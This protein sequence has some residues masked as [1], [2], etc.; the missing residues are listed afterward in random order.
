M[1]QSK[2]HYSVNGKQ[3]IFLHIPKTAGVSMLDFV[4]SHNIIINGHDIRSPQY[5]SLY[6]YTQKFTPDI[7]AFCFV[8]NPWDRA[9]SAYYYLEQEMG[10]EGDIADKYRYTHQYESFDD[11]VV[12]G[13]PHNGAFTDQMH[14]RTQSSWMKRPD[15]TYIPEFIGKFE[16]LQSDFNLLCDEIEV[17]RY[18]L[19]HENKSKR[20]NYREY[21][22]DASARIIA[23]LYQEDIDLQ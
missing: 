19:G 11:F 2:E 10:H 7:F 8:R 9:V 20:K 4:Y 5:L 1:S 18:V 13:L 14:F 21:Y 17:D 6:G 22:S 15:N 16:N 3:V 12:N 23:D